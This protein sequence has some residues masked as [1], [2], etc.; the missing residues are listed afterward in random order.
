LIFIINLKEITTCIS[1]LGVISS[2][3]VSNAYAD[4]ARFAKIALLLTIFT[5]EEI[6]IL[7]P[8]YL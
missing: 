6:Q 3:S 7:N 5:S 1:L 4:A 2:S 8:K